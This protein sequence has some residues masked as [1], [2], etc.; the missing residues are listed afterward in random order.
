MTI[1]WPKDGKE[2]VHVPAGHFA[3]GAKKLP[4]YLPEYWIDRTP[5]TNA[6]YW[7]F[8]QETDH[9]IPLLT[10]QNGEPFDEILN[11]PVESITWFDAVAYTEW[12]GKQLPM[13]E[14]WEKAARGEDGR[15]Y[16]WGNNPITPQMCNYS[17]N[18]E[19]PTPVDTY[20][21]KGNSPYGC[22]DMCGNV[23]EWTSSR[24]SYRSPLYVI[25]G[26]AWYH[27]IE[28]IGIIR[29]GAV[30]PNSYFWGRGF[31]CVVMKTPVEKMIGSF[32]KQQS[33]KERHLSSDENSG[34][35]LEQHQQYLRKIKSALQ[36]RSD[37]HIFLDEN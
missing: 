28:Q 33:K 18:V 23:Q 31:R 6:E 20:S 13:E 37:P 35:T 24:F 12:A 16:P 26:G 2:I 8:I 11:R 19:E 21:P 5:V 29:R 3:Y 15:Q 10:W 7:Q 22:M 34:L 4:L 9:R 32:T 30:R 1:V 27:E 36:E 14:Q 25:R 17:F